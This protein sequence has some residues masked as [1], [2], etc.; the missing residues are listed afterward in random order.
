M[1]SAFQ[2]RL[3]S[4][5]IKVFPTGGQRGKIGSGQMAAVLFARRRHEGCLRDPTGA[6]ID[7]QDLLGE[8]SGPIEFQNEPTDGSSFP[9][10]NWRIPVHGPGPATTSRFELVAIAFRHQTSGEQA[11]DAAQWPRTDTNDRADI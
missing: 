5:T 8:L 11:L 4:H 10:K 1:H 6:D 2:L 3:G 7:L 9:P